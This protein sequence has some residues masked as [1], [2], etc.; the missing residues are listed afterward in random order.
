MTYYGSTRVVVVNNQPP[1]CQPIEAALRRETWIRSTCLVP[2]IDA[3]EDE[4]I[5]DG[6]YDMLVV[7]YELLENGLDQSINT[8]RQRHPHLRIAIVGGPVDR[9]AISASISVGASGYVPAT[10][11]MDNAVAA[12]CYIAGGHLYAPSTPVLASDQSALPLVSNA[13]PADGRPL[14]HRQGQVMQLLALGKSNKEIARALGLAEGTI[15]VHLSSAYRT[16][17]AH[18]RAEAISSWLLSYY[19]RP[20]LYPARLAPALWETRQQGSSK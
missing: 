12:L 7:G 20:T 11:P 13:P 9:N 2:S 5:V 19:S 8:L 3:L 14:S 17:N 4:F 15:K 6:D 1:L 10:L 16:L 18:N